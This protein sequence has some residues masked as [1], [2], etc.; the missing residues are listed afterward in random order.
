M[1]RR[2]IIVTDIDS[3]SHQRRV[4]SGHAIYVNPAN[5]RTLTI[6]CWFNVGLMLDMSDFQP[7]EVVGRGSETQLQ[8][9]Q[10]LNYL[11]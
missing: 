10:N 4:S 3:T 2:V 1:L 9:G 6:I 11:I 5:R 7:V 8:V